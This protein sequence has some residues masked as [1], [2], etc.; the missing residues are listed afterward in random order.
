MIIHFGAES[1]QFKLYPGTQ[2]YEFWEV[3]PVPMYIYMYLY[4]VTNAEDV[5]NFKA[6]PI[7][8][9]VGPYTY[10]YAYYARLYCP[11]YCLITII[12]K[13]NSFQ[14]G[15]RTRQHRDARSQL[16]AKIPAEEM[17]AVCGRAEQRFS[18]RSNNHCER[19]PFGK[20]GNCT[21]FLNT[22]SRWVI[23]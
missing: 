8:Q 19:S 21:F 14:G 23:I 1:Q 22:L 7:L 5:I 20:I 2:M 10:T 3:S 11:I 12:F 9:Q 16:H 17:V 4:N 18:G 13:I 6:K 15:A